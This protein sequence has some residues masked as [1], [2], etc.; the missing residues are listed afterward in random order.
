MG[1]DSEF[2]IKWYQNYARP[3]VINGTVCGGMTATI[4]GSFFPAFIP[5]V[6]PIHE[7]PI[8]A[9]LLFFG[10]TLVIA[11]AS[12][13]L[14]INDP[15]NEG[16]DELRIWQVLLVLTLTVAS[17]LFDV[18]VVREWFDTNLV[19]LVEE[20]PG[21]PNTV[22]WILSYRLV[23]FTAAFFGARHAKRLLRRG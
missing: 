5:T 15:D 14:F 3:A 13:M 20:W 9:I 8:Q 21:C 12:S 7:E 4:G 23:G 1:T 22:W 17:I 2:K 11:L 10:A 18:L 19:R 16:G 6:M